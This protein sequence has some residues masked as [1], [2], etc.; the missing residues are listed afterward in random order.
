MNP[1]GWQEKAYVAKIGYAGGLVMKWTLKIAALLGVLLLPVLVLA[2]AATSTTGA[3]PDITTVEDALSLFKVMTGAFKGGTYAIGA[4]ALLTLLVAAARYFKALD[5][6]KI[7]DSWDK[8]VAMALAMGGS[9]AMGLWAGHD[10]MTI[11]STG[12]QV[13]VYSIGGWEMLLKPLRNK[14]LKKKKVG[15]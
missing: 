9:V 11:V 2:Q 6:I 12:V 13:G 7:P 4:S 1:Y 8:W 15:E 14:L 10:W 3:P 5:L